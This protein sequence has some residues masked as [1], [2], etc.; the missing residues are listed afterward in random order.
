MK[1]LNDPKLIEQLEADYREAFDNDEE[2]ETVGAIEGQTKDQGFLDGADL[3][4]DGYLDK[5]IPWLRQNLGFSSVRKQLEA[6]WPFFARHLAPDGSPAH[7][8]KDYDPKLTNAE[9]EARG[10]IPVE[11][12][13]HQYVGTSAMAERGFDGKNVILA[14]GTGVGKTLQC[15]MM[16]AYLRHLAVMQAENN[17]TMPNIGK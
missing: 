2:D 10:F 1:S 5:N 3:G 8:H 13:W 17:T 11:P 15:I 9:L 14:D 6:A 7:L 12:H 4:C 16:T